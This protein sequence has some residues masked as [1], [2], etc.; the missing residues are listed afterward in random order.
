MAPVP[1]NVKAETYLVRVVSLLICLEP[2]EGMLHLPLSPQSILMGLSLS[3]MFSNPLQMHVGSQRKWIPGRRLLLQKWFP[4]YHVTRM[5]KIS[6]KSSWPTRIG[7]SLRCQTPWFQR[8]YSVLLTSILPGVS[9]VGTELSTPVVRYR[10]S[11]YSELWQLD[12]QVTDNQIRP[13]GI[14]FMVDKAEE[15]FLIYT[16]WYLSCLTLHYCSSVGAYHVPCRL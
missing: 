4:W 2:L 12:Q 7:A 1:F 10:H 16:I 13:D 15:W 8:L 6:R 14:P 5:R 3:T 11:K 9:K